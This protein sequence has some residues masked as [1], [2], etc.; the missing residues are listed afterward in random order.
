MIPVR[1]AALYPRTVTGVGPSFFGVAIVPKTKAFHC[2]PRMAELG[3]PAGFTISKTE[4][5]PEGDFRVTEFTWGNFTL[6][7]ID[8]QEFTAD[9]RQAAY[10]GFLHTL[11]QENAHV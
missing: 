7:F 6:W 3:S 2:F 10:L 11:D 8:Q 4:A 9:E 5:L 1:D